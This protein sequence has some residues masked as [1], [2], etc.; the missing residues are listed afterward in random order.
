MKKILTIIA[1]AL[2][3]SSA[4]AGYGIFQSYAV[5]DASNRV[6]NYY[7]DL[8]ATSGNDDFQGFNLGTFDI[9]TSDYLTLNGFQLDVFADGGD[10]A[11]DGR[12]EWKINRITAPA[13][14]GSFVAINDT[15]A[16]SLG[17]NDERYEITNA[18]TNL[19]SGLVGTTAA[20]VTYELEVFV[21]SQ[22]DWNPVDGNPND[23]TYANNGGANYKA[24]FTVVPEPST[25]VALFSGLGMLAIRRRR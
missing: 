15:S 12:M 2:T 7:Y 8:N 9:S 10:N 6:G 13:S 20:P 17:G 23:T 11:L 22:V 25:L 1:C 24:T 3:S 16:T 18:N 21:A 4:F 14:G 5:I 19:L